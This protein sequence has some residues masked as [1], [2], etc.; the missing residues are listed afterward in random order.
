MYGEWHQQFFFRIEKLAFL[1]VLYS[2]L[3]N[4]IKGWNSVPP[5]FKSENSSP[6]KLTS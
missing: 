4:D 1:N 3:S 2:F 5:Y 6:D